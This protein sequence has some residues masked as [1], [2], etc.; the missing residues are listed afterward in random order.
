M[1]SVGNISINM[2]TYL[3]IFLTCLAVQSFALKMALNP[4]APIWNGVIKT[5]A[6][7]FKKTGAKWVRINCRRDLWTGP[8]DTNK[9]NGMTWFDAYDSIINDFVTNDV[10]VYMLVSYEL[11]PGSNYDDDSWLTEYSNSFNQ[12]V[13][14]FKDRVRVYESFNEPNNWKAPSTPI[15]SYQAFAK[16][17]EWIYKTV[18]IDHWGDPEWQV[19]LVSGALFSHDHDTVATYFN[20]TFNYGKNSLGWNDIK[21]NYGTY[22]LDGLGYHIY[23]AQGPNLVATVQ[24][25]INGNLNAIWNV[26]TNHEGAETKKKMW[27]SEFGWNCASVDTGEQ[28][29]NVNVAYNLFQNDS[30]IDYA[31]WFSLNNFGDANQW[32]L[33][34]NGGNPAIPADRRPSWYAYFNQSVTNRLDTLS[35]NFWFASSSVHLPFQPSPDDILQKSGVTASVLE[36]GFYN[37]DTNFGQIAWLT[38]SPVTGNF[39]VGNDNFGAAVLLDNVTPES[40]PSL[41]IQYNFLNSLYV[42]N[43]LVFGGWNDSRQ[44]LHYSVDASY[45]YSSA[46]FPLVRAANGEPG[47]TPVVADGSKYFSVSQIHDIKGYVGTGMIDALKFK[48]YMV[49]NPSKTFFVDA[50]DDTSPDAIMGSIVRE[51]DVYGEV[52]EPFLFINCYLLFIIWKFIFLKNKFRT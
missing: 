42:T 50:L 22:P 48:F 51:I 37:N 38:N 13:N 31:G 46:F 29:R 7:S 15:I 4:N 35:T 6:A 28:A 20:N 44:F 27:I 8:S 2:K 18:K 30:R 10:Q 19:T 16:S 26:F 47:L 12:V 34:V 39:G 43:I 9:H 32:G 5:D 52:P 11:V 24:S 40:I 1:F 49:G 45:E 25:K 23:V 41:T 17:L 3:F 21:T 33:V 36:G 14:H